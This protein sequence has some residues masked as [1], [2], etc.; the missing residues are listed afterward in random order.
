MKQV[1]VMFFVTLGFFFYSGV[2]IAADEIC[3]DSQD[4]N[5]YTSPENDFTCYCE[6]NTSGI[7]VCGNCVWWAR[8]KRP[9]LENLNGTPDAVNWYSNAE[10]NGFAVGDIPVVG[11]IAVFDYWTTINGV[12]RN[13]GHVAYI[14]SVIEDYDGDPKN[15]VFNVSEMG[16]A[17]WDGVH[18][19]SYSFP[20]DVIHGLVGFIYPVGVYFD[21]RT[22]YTEGTQNKIVLDAFLETYKKYKNIIGAPYDNGGDVFV[23]EYK[24]ITDDSYSVWIQDFYNPDTD[25]HYALVLNDLEDP[26]KAYLLQGAI[27]NFY[28]NNDG[29]G[30]YGVPFTDEIS[31]Y[32]AASPYTTLGDMILPNGYENSSMYPKDIVVQKFKLRKNGL[33][34][35]EQ[36]R[37]IAHDP[38]DGTT[39]HFPL[40]Q[41]SLDQMSC[42]GICPETGDYI[43]Y[44]DEDNHPWPMEGQNTVPTQGIWFTKPGFYNFVLD[45]P[46]WGVSA[47]ITEGNHQTIGGDGGYTYNEATICGSVSGGIPGG[48][49]YSFTPD[50]GQI[51]FWFELTD[52]YDSL[53]VE[54]KWYKPNG[55][56]LGDCDYRVDEPNGSWGSFKAWRF[57]N[58]ADLNDFGK[59]RV[60]L[61]INDKKIDTKYF[62][63]SGGESSDIILPPPVLQIIIN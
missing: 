60:E 14:E 42:A 45:E 51:G 6:S 59:W 19:G 13:V 41:F 34:Y 5:C 26:L 31:G 46:G 17:V 22:D 57:L 11:S 7:T 52:I 63:L 35:N 12:Y 30:N 29:S 1:F 39:L 58:V 37:T 18:E 53:D 28:M 49:T 24:G 48:K 2:V 25:K 38:G 20:N 43:Y 61:Y 40:G 55:D 54:W 44:N 47:Y 9:D 21:E 15:N 32:L 10:S 33:Y 8:Y 56:F 50:D 3:C 27:R 36:R 62:E 4:E 23:H 16:Y